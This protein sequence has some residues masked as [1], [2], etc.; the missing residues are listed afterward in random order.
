[1]YRP[2]YDGISERESKMIY[3]RIPQTIEVEEFK[4]DQHPW[5]EGIHL[6]LIEYTDCLGS[7]VIK[8]VFKTFEKIEKTLNVINKTETQKVVAITESPRGG[9]MV[10]Y[11]GDFLI[12]ENDK[13][14][15]VHNKQYIKQNYRRIK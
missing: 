11:D 6:Q 1:M 15:E 5:R 8:E 9:V 10:I 4:F 2:S 3:E 13:I 7:Y 14:V 12:I